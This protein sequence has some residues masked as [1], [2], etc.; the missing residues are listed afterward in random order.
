MGASKGEAKPQVE[1]KDLDVEKVPIEEI[2]NKELYL[3]ELMSKKKSITEKHVNEGIKPTSEDHMMM[4]RLNI[5]ITEYMQ[6]IFH[7]KKKRKKPKTK[8]VLDPL[9]PVFKY[10][11][12][13][14]EF[15]VLTW[16]WEELYGLHEEY[17]KLVDDK[18]KA[19]I[20]SKDRELHRQ[21]PFYPDDDDDEDEEKEKEVKNIGNNN[22]FSQNQDDDDDE[23]EEEEDEK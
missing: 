17:I 19:D 21:D 4:T 1:I 23:G 9:L 12:L 10:S 16:Q 13:K 2:K 20:F 22:F 6:K 14:K 7:P 3:I 15:E 5:E 8:I 18:A 11:E